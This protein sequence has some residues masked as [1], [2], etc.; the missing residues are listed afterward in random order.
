M[1]LSATQQSELDEL[2][3]MSKFS[4]I[5]F[6]K[7]ATMT[8]TDFNLRM[9]QAKDRCV[10]AAVIEAYVMIDEMLNRIISS[11]FL[12][13]T[14]SKAKLFKEYVL[15]ELYILK[16]LALVQQFHDL[17]KGVASSIKQLN[18][19]RNAVAHGFD[20]KKRRQFVD[21]GGVLF[22]RKDLYTPAGHQFFRK[23]MA[24][25]M[26]ILLSLIP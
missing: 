7:F 10:R 9:R 12:G 23:D 3:E 22:K 4:E 26:K 1:A 6:S 25:V 14:A 11:H 16:K 13:K 18:D 24:S 17:D 2:K 5:D 19:V 21:K 15:D 8:T 20:P